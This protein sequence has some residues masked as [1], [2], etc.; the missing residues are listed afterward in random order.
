M[1]VTGENNCDSANCTAGELPDDQ[2]YCHNEG[3]D[4]SCHDDEDDEE[5]Q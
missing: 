2:A 3:C 5:N 4:C 1:A